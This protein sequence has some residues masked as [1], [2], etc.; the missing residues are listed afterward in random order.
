MGI[1]CDKHWY[2]EFSVHYITKWR[3]RW[4]SRRTFRLD[5]AVRNCIKSSIVRF[6]KNIIIE[7]F[8]RTTFAVFT[9][10]E[11]F[12]KYVNT[13]LLQNNL[14]VQWPPFFF[15]H[16]FSLLILLDFYP[17]NFCLIV[18]YFHFFFK[19]KATRTLMQI[20]SCLILLIEID[21]LNKKRMNICFCFSDPSN[22][23]YFVAM[24]RRIKSVWVCLNN[25]SL[26]T[27]N[28]Q[29]EMMMTE[30]LI[31]IRTRTAIVWESH[32]NNSEREWKKERLQIPIDTG[33]GREKYN[34]FLP[35]L[36]HRI[37]TQTGRNGITLFVMST[38]T[39]VMICFGNI[40]NTNVFNQPLHSNKKSDFFSTR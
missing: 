39:L 8:I 4:E 38:N 20:E 28:I 26:A 40:H 23:L 13:W 27:Y 14:A 33:R 10:H 5:G 2:I 1:D 36:L 30:C 9:L 37:N 16:F 29:A 24:I 18:C 31:M 21:R 35:S 34:S 6:K 7:T 22:R 19:K 25:Q 12:I 15:F 3:L 17:H 32:T 11:H